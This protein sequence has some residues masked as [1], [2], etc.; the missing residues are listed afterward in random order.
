MKEIDFN[1]IKKF[2]EIN[3]NKTIIIFARSEGSLKR[4]INIFLKNLQINLIEIE[5]FNKAQKKENIY[6]SKLKL[7]E[8]IKYENYI[9]LNEKT[10]F[11]YNIPTSRHKS[12]N[13]EFFLEEINKFTK[14]SILVHSEYGFCKFIDVIKVNINES[15]HDC[16]KL[17][18]ANKQNLLLPIE[19]LNFISKYGDDEIKNFKLDHL[20]AAHWQ[21]RKANAKNKI[22]DIAK[23]LMVIAAKR[24][25]SKSYK[26]KYDPI[27]YEKFCSTFPF[28]ETDD[29]IKV[30]DEVKSDFSKSVPSDRLIVGD[31]AF[32]KTEIIIRAT[33]LASISKIQSLILVPT[34]LLSRQHYIQ[35]HFYD[36]KFQYHSQH[37]Q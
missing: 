1:F 5:N 9:F 22:K 34:T 19:N 4:I 13:K 36:S 18:F 27:L 6:I 10:L 14:N 28:V 17:E 31:V 2:I 32:G 35:F 29:Q 11:G 3:K 8:S 25:N 21:K 7:D 37:H 23:K 12:I 26:I 33:F 15:F 24:H 20:G 16:L 30:L